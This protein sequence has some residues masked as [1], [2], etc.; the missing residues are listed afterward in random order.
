MEDQTRTSLRFGIMVDD[1]ALEA[2]KVDAVKL[3][4]EGGMTL[5]LVIRNGG[6]TASSSR[7]ASG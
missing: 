6:T 1:L 7:R 2:W 5:A 4:V 3:L